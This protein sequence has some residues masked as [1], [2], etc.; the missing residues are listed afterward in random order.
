MKTI[1]EAMDN[2]RWIHDEAIRYAKANLSASKAAGVESQVEKYA[3]LASKESDAR[4]K[5]YFI[6]RMLLSKEAAQLMTNEFY[7]KA[8]RSGTISDIAYGPEGEFSR[9]DT[10]SYGVAG[11]DKGMF[12][13]IATGRDSNPEVIVSIED[14][15]DKIFKHPKMKSNYATVL[16]ASLMFGTGK[17]SRSSSAKSGLDLAGY[18][19][20]PPREYFLIQ[21]QIKKIEKLGVDS[22]D[23][24][25]SM[26]LYGYEKKD[27]NTGKVVTRVQPMLS[28]KVVRTARNDIFPSVIRDVVGADNDSEVAKL[29]LNRSMGMYHESRD[30]TNIIINAINNY[31]SGV[32]VTASDLISAIVAAVHIN[33]TEKTELSKSKYFRGDLS[34][35]A[36][37]FM[38]AA[39]KGGEDNVYLVQDLF[40]APAL[41]RENKKA[42][43]RK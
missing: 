3:R 36:K 26:V 29:V 17:G 12:S 37:R 27:E 8:I 23:I 19:D 33:M 11:V 42:A 43:W 41:D 10:M 21:E 25:M 16:I 5:E 15:L 40:L 6:N 7:Q 24:T 18:M 30:K 22:D 1:E 34:T 13:S 32:Q 4:R 35:V 9:I 31:L 28:E 14:L 20:K 38:A 39:K 2:I